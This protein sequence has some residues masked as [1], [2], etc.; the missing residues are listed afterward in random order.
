MPITITDFILLVTVKLN[1]LKAFIQAFFYN[2][3]TDRFSNKK[4]ENNVRKS[5]DALFMLMIFIKSLLDIAMPYN[6]CHY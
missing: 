2:R 1:F 4:K 5:V 6:F 3:S